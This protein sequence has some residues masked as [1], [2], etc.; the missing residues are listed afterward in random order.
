[1]KPVA[2]RD[3]CRQ[4]APRKILSFQA[5]SV[6]L[7]WLALLLLASTAAQGAAAPGKAR[8]GIEVGVQPLGYPAAMIGAV[9]GRD[10]ILKQQLARRGY[11]FTPVPFRKGN[12]MVDLFGSRLDAGL[13]GDMPT[14]RLAVKTDVCAVGL[15]KQTFSSVVSYKVTLLAQLKGKRVG[16][17]EGSSAHHTLLQALASVGLTDRDL[18]LVPVEI[19]AMPGAL[20]A[21]RIDAFAAWEPAVSI[22]LA[23]APEARILFRGVSSDYFVLSRELVQR[24]PEAALEVVAGFVRA[25]SW[26]RKSAANV[27]LAAVWAKKDGE[28]LS[29]RPSRLALS[30]AVEI[31]HRDILDVPSAPAILRRS[32]GKP[33][34]TDEFSFLK[35]LGKIPKNTELQRLHD[36]FAYDGL[37]RVL[38]SPRRYRLAEFDYQP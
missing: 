27:E 6:L 28:A 37:Q 31:A 36:A 15:V 29:G 10:A 30:Q 23:S 4:K 33:P 7:L 21:G 20:E 16:Y 8:K 32:V 2:D 18:T 38:K 5:H 9:I 22:A 24:D 17:S 35:S 11:S 3:R 14:I 25:L 1:M 13:L 19:D 12:D 34:L 26:M